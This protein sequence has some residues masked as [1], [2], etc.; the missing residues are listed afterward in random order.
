MT[1]RTRSVTAAAGLLAA[2]A[3]IAV[4][5]ATVGAT[6]SGKADSGTAYFS[7]THSVGA[8]QFAAGN[9]ID[10]VLGTGA[11]TYRIKIGST[12][13]KISIMVPSVTIY[14]ATGSLSGTATATLVTGAKTQTISNGKL[15]LTKGTGSQ[16]GHSL[17][18]TFSGT[19]N[20]TANQIVIHDKGTYK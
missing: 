19:G 3:L 10:K 15:N 20:L 6:S 17:R 7:I 1:R 16:K 12:N 14:T 18:A 4:T 8:T 11:V 2:S 9:S 5:A 13:G